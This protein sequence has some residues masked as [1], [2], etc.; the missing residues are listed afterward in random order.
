MCCAD[1]LWRCGA[2]GLHSR[3]HL[4]R[5]I[6]TPSIAPDAMP[7]IASATKAACNTPTIS[8]ESPRIE[9]NTATQMH[10][11]RR[12]MRVF[13]YPHLRLADVVHSARSHNVDLLALGVLQRR[14]RVSR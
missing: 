2:E 3:A 7:C 10:I 8:Y 12:I 14:A 5:S 9:R 13:F 4:A 11:A 6:K 1:V